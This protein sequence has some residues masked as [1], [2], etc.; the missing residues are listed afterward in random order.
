MEN[1]APFRV[2]QKVVALKDSVC[3]YFNKGD[4]F[5][6]AGIRKCCQWSIDVGCIIGSQFFR[7]VCG[8]CHM[9]HG[10]SGDIR[11]CAAKCFAP[12]NPYSNSVSKQ[13]AEEAIKQPIE[14]DV[15]VKRE[16]V[17]N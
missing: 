12:Y 7:Q 13:L 16:V 9:L 10:Y 15:P 14:T 8:D 1:N 3:G 6:V 2:G 11:W 5:T 17:N 4:I